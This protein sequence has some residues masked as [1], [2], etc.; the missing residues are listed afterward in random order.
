[1][2]HSGVKNVLKERAEKGISD[3]EEIEEY[4]KYVK[5]YLQV[6]DTK[7]SNYKKPLGLVID[8]V[9]LKNPYS[10]HV[11]DSLPVQVLFKGKPLSNLIL[12]AG[13][14]GHE[15]PLTQATTDSDGKAD[16]KLSKTGRWYIRGINLLQVDKEDHSYESYW[17]TLTFEVK[18]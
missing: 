14:A 2:E 1:L 18:E 4:S 12:Y 7:S 15:K 13:A 10:L 16:I 5:A 3:R 17:T 9:P 8:T 6:D 11:G